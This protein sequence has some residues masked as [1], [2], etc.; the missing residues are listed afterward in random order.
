MYKMKRDYRVVLVLMMSLLTGMMVNAQSY[1][2]K[3]NL[4][5]GKEYRY[6]QQTSMRIIQDLG[7]MEQ[8]MTNELKGVTRFVPVGNEGANIV[9]KTCFESMEVSIQ[10]LL[11][12]MSYDSSKPLVETDRMAR[13]YNDIIGKDFTI[14]I[15]PFGSV[16]RIEGVSEII[17][18]AVKA[19]GNIQP[20]A[21][22]QIRNVLKSQLGEEALKG[23]MEM[24]LA[25][26]PNT[27]KKV[28]EKWSTHAQL[29]SI[30]KAKLNSSWTLVD[31][32][33]NKWKLKGSGNVISGD[34]K[35]SLNGIDVNIKVNGKQQSEYELNQTDGWFIRGKQEQDLQGSFSMSGDNP[36]L[37]AF[38][39]PVKI[40]SKTII[41]RR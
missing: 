6:Y 22:A 35:T 36:Q 13:I 16:V 33:D 8:E 27:S 31:A 12:S 28:G 9:L 14:V 24:I 20:K 38:E 2:L 4:K 34:G 15:T 5:S 26:Y 21:A 7:I 41:E 10:S 11:Y 30:L 40:K 23:N 18:N 17:N 37:Q 1:N 25:I 39:I 29:A 3:F 19:A 32:S